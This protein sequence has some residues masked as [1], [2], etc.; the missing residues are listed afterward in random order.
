MEGLWEDVTRPHYMGE[1]LS[2][3]PQSYH[4][5]VRVSDPRLYFVH[6]ILCCYDYNVHVEGLLPANLCSVTFLSS[7][8]CYKFERFCLQQIQMVNK[9]SSFKK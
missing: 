8:Q 1:M 2:N 7:E 6:L 3:C 9:T 5:K 4:I